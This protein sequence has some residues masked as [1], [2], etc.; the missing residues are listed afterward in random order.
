[1]DRQI[2]QQTKKQ[3]KIEAE[4]NNLNQCKMVKTASTWI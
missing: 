2:N 4:T 1:M 3:T